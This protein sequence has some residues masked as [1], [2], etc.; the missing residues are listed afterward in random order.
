[1]GTLNTRVV[2]QVGTT[3]LSVFARDL[4]EGANGEIE[5]RLEGEHSSLLRVNPSSGVVQTAAPLDR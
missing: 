5:Y 3:V 1:M 2:S 4:D